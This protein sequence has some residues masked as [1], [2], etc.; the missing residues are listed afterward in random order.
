MFFYIIR[1]SEQIFIFEVEA[2]MLSDYTFL[3][4]DTAFFK[5]FNTTI[6]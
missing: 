3:W 1:F 6:V 4:S 5:K 2:V